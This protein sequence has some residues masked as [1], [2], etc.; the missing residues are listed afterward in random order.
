MTNG[1]QKS[2]PFS[3]S[4]RKKSKISVA[5]KGRGLGYFGDDKD[6]IE[7]LDAKNKMEKNFKVSLDSQKTNDDGVV[8]YKNIP[9]GKYIIEVEGNQDFQ[10]SV[11]VVNILNEEDNDL[12][13]IYVG[14]KQR[15][16]VD[17][18]FIFCQMV[19]AEYESLNF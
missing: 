14:V 7:Q 12:V 19:Q 13:R 11:K 16:D 8:L 17:V 6:K 1:S 10:Q 15:I 18:E 5:K 9:V 2:R 4:T 3:A